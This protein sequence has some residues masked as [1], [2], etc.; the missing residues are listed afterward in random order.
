MHIR[1]DDRHGAGDVHVVS[2]EILPAER[3][4]RRTKGELASDVASRLAPA[5]LATRGDDGVLRC[6]ACAHRCA[7]A[8][9][10]EGA[11]GVRHARGGRL[12][13]PRGFIARRYVRD[14][15]TNTVYHVEPGAKALTFGL[16]GCDLRCP[17]CHN[18]RLSQALREDVPGEHPI[19]VTADE[20]ADEAVR[21]GCRVM[22]AA[23]NE[24]MIAAEWVREVFAA[25][26]ARGLRTLVV[27]DG[28]TT[29]EALTYLRP[30]TDAFR[31]DLK[32]STPEQY[33]TLGGRLEP[34]L[35]GIQ[36]AR[37]LGYWIEVVTLVVPGFN[38]DEAG[39]RRLA[40]T[41]A[42]IDPDMP[43]HL[44]AFQHRYKLRDRAPCPPD[45]LVSLAGAGYARGLRFVYVGNVT[46][47][48]PELEHTRC[49]GCHSVLV[50]RSGWRT[51]R[52]RLT[53]H[54]GCP[55]CGVTIPGLF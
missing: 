32:G 46:R 5:A 22:C 12:F 30:V 29:P 4:T 27:S 31:V 39:L 1:I 20:L 25:A 41:L 33:R 26:R 53:S 49:P 2:D 21:S 36:T 23:Y 11:C 38:D 52:S 19:D 54:G 3:L 45:R 10:R 34:V 51:T 42:S 15:E 13:A 24:P 35:E 7:F 50:E 55:D 18:W 48:F 17:Y 9:D 6:T 43:W 37:A 16:Y 47:V 40:K 8:G 44:N 14:V 28:H